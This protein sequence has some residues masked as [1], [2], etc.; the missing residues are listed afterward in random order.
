V[1]KNTI[2]S[3]TINALENKL[4][5]TLKKKVEPL[6]IL[7]SGGADSTLLAE[8]AKRC[9]NNNN[10][11]LLH[12]NLPFSPQKE[13]ER[14]TFFAK[15][16]N[17]NL[18]TIN[19]DLLQIE[20]IRLNSS[21]RCYFCKKF[22]IETIL[23]NKSL[24]KK[25]TLCDGTVVDDFSDFRPGLKATEELS[26]SH[27][28][29]DA[30]FGKIEIRRLARYYKIPLWNMPAS[31][32]LA[33]RI[34]TNTEIKIE[35]LKK[36]E[37]AENYLASLGLHGSRVRF[38]KNNTASIELPLIYLNMLKRYFPMI[39]DNLKTFGFKTIQINDS[40]YKKGAMN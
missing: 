24:P 20:Q 13:T 7:V 23:A 2:N 26:V 35:H 19:V 5:S 3:L 4:F 18:I 33:S 22:I 11:I 32:C 6:G 39:N 10:L 8:T 27:P 28:L 30:G 21:Q 37:K 16:N 9:V 34:P 15:N 40:G 14:I 25:I 36:I 1:Q 38:M 17:L 29:A 31:P 12:A